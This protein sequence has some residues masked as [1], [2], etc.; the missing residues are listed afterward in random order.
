MLTKLF[1]KIGAFFRNLLSN[2]ASR[3]TKLMVMINKEASTKVVK[4]LA[5]GSGIVASGVLVLGPN[6]S[7][8]VVNMHYFFQQVFPLLLGIFWANY[9]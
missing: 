9:R 1:C 5:P 2:W 6:Y 4:F 3:Q 7:G 8:Y